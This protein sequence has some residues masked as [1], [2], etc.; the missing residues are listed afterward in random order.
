MFGAIF[1]LFK[2]AHGTF[3]YFCYTMVIFVEF[4]FDLQ[5][6]QHPSVL[7]TFLPFMIP[8]SSSPSL[9]VQL[10]FSLIARLRI[11]VSVSSHGT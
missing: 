4:C 1:A 11:A 2:E 5:H 8:D 7:G 6:T 10:Q 9:D 3:H